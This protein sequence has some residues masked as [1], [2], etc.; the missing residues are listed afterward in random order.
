MKAVRFAGP[1]QVMIEEIPQPTCPEGGVLTEVLACAICGSDIRTW[2]HNDGSSTE[3]HGHECVMRVIETRADSD[4]VR[5]GD[6]LMLCVRFR[7]GS[8]GFAVDLLKTSA[9]ARHVSG[10]SHKAVLHSTDPLAEKRLS[11]VSCFGSQT[12]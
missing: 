8:V 5:V 12:P 6:R 9:A 1:E 3:I 2:K 4:A 10:R 7:A 11:G